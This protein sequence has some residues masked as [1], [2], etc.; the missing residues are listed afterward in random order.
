MASLPSYRNHSNEFFITNQ[1]TGF[2]MKGTLVLKGLKSKHSSIL[3]KHL[4]SSK[5]KT[6]YKKPYQTQMI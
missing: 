2:Y 3:M 4:F 5:R 6:I 1:L